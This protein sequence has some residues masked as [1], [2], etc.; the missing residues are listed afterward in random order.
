[1]PPDPEA[2]QKQDFGAWLQALLLQHAVLLW[3]SA[4]VGL[5]PL[6]TCLLLTRGIKAVM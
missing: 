6:G 1:M 2:G 4:H 3:V 5:G